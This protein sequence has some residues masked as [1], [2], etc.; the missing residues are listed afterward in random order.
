M[1]DVSKLRGE[2]E[3]WIT[4]GH[5]WALA[6]TTLCIGLLS[7]FVGLLVGRSEWL[8]PEPAQDNTALVSPALEVDALDEFLARVE[9]AATKDA[10]EEVLTFPGMLPGGEVEEPPEEHIDDPPLQTIVKPGREQPVPPVKTPV[11]STLPKGGWAIQVGSYTTEGEADARMEEVSAR[12]VECYKVSA[13]VDGIT[14]H[15]LRV[16]GFRTRQDA[17]DAL[18]SISD[19][20][21]APDAIVVRAP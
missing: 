19:K 14:R 18:G 17:T 10:P 7:F 5:L 12:G 3:I 1:R 15:R 2:R 21:G 4:R 6:V 13:V 16:G 11:T 8:R 9:E 20:A